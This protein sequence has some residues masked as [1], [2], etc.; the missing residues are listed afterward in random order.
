MIL[1]TPRL[2]GRPVT[3]EDL[4]WL[5]RIHGDARAAATLTADGGLVPFARS[6]AVLQ[7]FL[8]GD[9]PGLWLFFRRQDQDFVGYAGLRFIVLEGARALELLYAASPD[10]WR[11]GYTSE[12]AASILPQAP[13]PPI[14][15]TLPH[16]L[17]SRG[18]M[19][20]LGMV[21]ER[22]FIHAGLPHVL[23]RLP[24]PA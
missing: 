19:A 11:Q 3:A 2:T 12:A 20:R 8:T 4:P 14:A 22:D 6:Q 15:F 24:S 21:W 17:G 7:A 1:T 16:N 9:H 13:Q 23:Y 10:Y 5:R 18:V